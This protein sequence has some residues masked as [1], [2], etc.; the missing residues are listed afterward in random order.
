MLIVRPYWI[1]VTFLTP[2]IILLRSSGSDELDLDAQRV[3]LTLI[4]TAVALAFAVGVR[5]V[6]HRRMVRTGEVNITH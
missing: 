2:A 3:I 5:E 6:N 4:G 1:F